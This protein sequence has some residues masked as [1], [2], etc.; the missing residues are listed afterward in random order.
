MEGS[1][2]APRLP[3]KARKGRVPLQFMEPA[4]SYLYIFR[5]FDNEGGERSP[6]PALPRLSLSSRSS[7]YTQR[8][9]PCRVKV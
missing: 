9:E 3:E 1:R 5:A 8:G 6:V 4:P 2:P 7:K